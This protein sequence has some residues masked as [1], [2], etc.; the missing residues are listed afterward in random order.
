MAT[1]VEAGADFARLLIR[2]TKWVEGT[3]IGHL[4]SPYFGS[5]NWARQSSCI[6]F[7]LS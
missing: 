7:S 5:L 1:S 4:K 6:R 2:A 3:D